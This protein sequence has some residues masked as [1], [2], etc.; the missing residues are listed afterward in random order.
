MILC[1]NYCCL[2]NETL[3][4]KISI[5]IVIGKLTCNK[6][7]CKVLYVEVFDG[8]FFNA[9]VLKHLNTRSIKSVEMKFTNETI[10]QE[11]PQIECKQ[12]K[13]TRQKKICQ[14][15]LKADFNSGCLYFPQM[16][17]QSF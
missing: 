8:F 14:I 7:N 3:H 16:T 6:L 1:C 2:Y 11:I 13:S 5:L 4:S 9:R 17:S 10:K 15:T 12:H